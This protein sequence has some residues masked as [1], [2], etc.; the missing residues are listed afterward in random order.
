MRR[1]LGEILEKHI[2]L[3]RLVLHNNNNGEHVDFLNTRSEREKYSKH[4]HK[5]EKYPAKYISVIVDGMDQNKTDIPHIISN[6]K[7]MAGS[8]KLET[9]ITGIRAHAW[10]L[11]YHGDRLWSISS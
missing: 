8:Y 2:R 6:P 1:W 5:S 11:H 7:A 10:P 4:R 3:E 9:H